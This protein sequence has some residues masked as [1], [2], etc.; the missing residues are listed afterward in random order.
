M[1]Y[2]DKIPYESCKG[3]AY[4]L[5]LERLESNLQLIDK[6]QKDAGVSIIMA[7]K[8]YANW[9]TFPLIGNYLSGA[10]ASSLNEARLIY[11][12]M[13]A[14]VHAYFVA[15][16]QD[17]FD[18]LLKYCSH[19]TFN[20]VG[21]YERFKDKI[22]SSGY[23]ISVGLRVNPEFSLVETDLYNPASPGSRLG[24]APDSLVNG[25][26]EGI[27]GLHFHTLCESTSFDLEKTLEALEEKYGQFF[28]QLKWINMGGGHLMTRADYD[29]KHLI[30]LLKGFK[31]KHK[32]D[33]I[34]EPGSAIVWRT[35]ELVA[36]ILDIHEARG[37]K[38]L[39][40]DVSFTA[41]MPDTLEMPY[42][43]DV[44]GQIE[45]SKEGFAYRI[46]GL[47]CLSGDYL[48]EYYFAQPLEIGQ[49]LIFADMIHYTTVKTTMF[50]GINHPSIMH[51]D[52]KSLE[53]VRSFGYEDYKNRMA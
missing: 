37:I 39:I 10:T 23:E 32:L 7:L 42:R 34:M 40:L 4:I 29:T 12:E 8:A 38:T 19:I 45:A 11:E 25:W 51:W 20:S 18:E 30:G 36:E 9:R 27:D 28:P 46:G 14:K 6:V 47:S 15:Y 3:P 52:G 35:G 24:I 50:N 44:I 21:Q 17:E 48:A 2:S 22:T 1:L 41:H 53:T 31:E 5:D 13:G 43:P 26:P 49:K 16:R 33:I